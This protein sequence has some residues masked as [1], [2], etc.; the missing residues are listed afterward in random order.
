MTP[1]ANA[2]QPGTGLVAGVDAGRLGKAT[3][4]TMATTGC[5][6]SSPVDFSTFWS[7]SELWDEAVARQLLIVAV[8]MPLGLP[9]AT[10]EWRPCETGARELLGEAREKAVFRSPP[11]C[12]LGAL[13]HDDAD[14]LAVEAGGTIL[15]GDTY[16]LL[17]KCRDAREALQPGAFRLSAW[18]QV[19]EVHAEVCFWGLNG[20]QPTRFGKRQQ[21]GED[22]RLQLLRPEF[23]NL[24]TAVTEAANRAGYELDQYDLLDAA[25]AAWTARRVASRTAEDLGGGEFDEDGFPMSIWI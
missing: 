13:D 8:D 17:P 4:W 6:E 22:E 7:F 9:T 1:S 18:P 20:R 25:A 16:R 12:T 11:L 23:S 19:A 3:I 10:E 14:R 15:H 5:S 21:A 2:R 24:A